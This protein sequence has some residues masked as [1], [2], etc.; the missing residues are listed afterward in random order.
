MEKIIAIVGLIFGIL[1]LI[2]FFKIWCMCDDV[3]RLT[4][5]LCGSYTSGT[6]EDGMDEESSLENLYADEKS[7]RKRMVEDLHDVAKRAV[8]VFPEEY[9]SKYGR[10]PEEELAEVIQKYREIYENIGEPFPKDIE[11]I[12]TLEDLWSRFQ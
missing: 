4:D 8:G 5:H 1:N 9:A 11:G 10:Y 3:K 2:L 7:V 6:N 12:C